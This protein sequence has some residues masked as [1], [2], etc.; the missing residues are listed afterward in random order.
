MSKPQII[1]LTGKRQVGKSTLC[2]RLVELM[3][4][5]GLAVAGLLTRRT[6]PH[7]LEVLEL[8]SGRAYPLTL[9]FEATEGIAFSNFRMDPEAMA[10]SA[11]A[12]EQSFPT[13]VF[14]LDEVGPLELVHHKGWIRALGL[15]AQSDYKAAFVVVRP[16]LLLEA[17]LQLPK[18]T[19]TVVHVLVDNR[20]CLP[21]QLLRTA[22]RLCVDLETWEA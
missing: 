8:A 15:L 16:E 12:L 11:L 1:L 22:Q 5:E 3:R 20:D 14:V 10:R 4:A 9:P 6:G 19:Y 18:P 2:F 21:M 17:I 13:D 7:D